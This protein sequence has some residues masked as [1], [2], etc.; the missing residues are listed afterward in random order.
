V[1]EEEPFMILS[2]DRGV[3][4]RQRNYG[5][6]GALDGQEERV[7]YRLLLHVEDERSTDSTADQ[8]MFRNKALD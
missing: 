8:N 1:W 5:D 7:S 3:S 4:H 6:E 2:L